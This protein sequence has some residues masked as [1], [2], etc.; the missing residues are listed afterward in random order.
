MLTTVF[1]LILYAG[2]AFVISLVANWVSSLFTK[3]GKI[4]DSP[5]AGRIAILWLVV[6]SLP[7]GWVEFN[8]ARHKSEFTDVIE[9]A[10]KKKQIEGEFM[11]AKVQHLWGDRA[12]LLVVTEEREE[13]GGTYRDMYQFIC[14]R[15]KDGW[16][17]ET[18][19][20]INT[21]KGDSAGFVFPP[22]W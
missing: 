12:K 13:W 18:V 19:K 3:T 17:L 5:A 11:Y 7:Y 14:V 1:G 22:Y 20:P 10:E 21:A 9:Y 8:S 6:M 4:G 16:E 2:V 15:D